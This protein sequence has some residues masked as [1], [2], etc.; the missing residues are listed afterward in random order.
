MVRVRLLRGEPQDEA[1]GRRDQGGGR[2]RRVAALASGDN[3]Q[4]GAQRVKKRRM[5]VPKPLS[6]APP[7]GGAPPIPVREQDKSL[8]SQDEAAN[9]WSCCA[10]VSA[11]GIRG[12]RREHHFADKQ[13][14][15]G[16]GET[17]EMGDEG[18]REMEQ[19]VE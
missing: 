3:V 8:K 10:W 15:L 13:R 14:S 18:W 5:V 9:K 6:R 12:K 1:H 7:I 16:S 17:T 2:S 11:D 19:E 4:R